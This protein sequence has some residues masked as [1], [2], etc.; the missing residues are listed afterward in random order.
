M[1]DA[2]WEITIISEHSVTT[3]AANVSSPTLLQKT[4]FVFE[5]FQANSLLPQNLKFIILV[6]VLYVS[7]ANY[8]EIGV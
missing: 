7:M 4:R 8:D 6:F 1:A 3:P 2:A 5:I